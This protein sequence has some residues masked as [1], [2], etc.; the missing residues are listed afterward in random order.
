MASPP[1][2]IDCSGKLDARGMEGCLHAATSYNGDQRR[3]PVV[4]L[5]SLSFVDPAG[6]VG[7][8]LLVEHFC[9][10]GPKPVVH[11]PE[12]ASVGH[13]LLR[14]GLRRVLR[15]RARNRGAPR[16]RPRQR[17]TSALLELSIIEDTADVDELLGRLTD[18]VSRI[19]KAEL[20]YLPAD[21]HNFAAVIAELCRNIVDHSGSI[22]FVAAQRYTR[23]DHDR[24]AIIS[25]GD[26][27]V[28]LRATLGS[29]YPVN[30]W[31]DTEVLR[32][33]LLPEFSRHP[34]R[35]MGLTFVEKVASDYRGSL[36]LRSGSSRIYIR[37][38]RLFSIPG[39]PFPGTQATISLR[40]RAR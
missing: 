9:H 28:G 35:G 25:V 26:V 7:L 1:T 34:N 2:T 36:H 29:R 23:D 27:G 18:R 38:N 6:L 20:H 5:S 24:F 33:S 32:K 13:Y 3:S 17:V 16:G 39:A 10:R 31:S 12:D 21:V 8:A 19:L 4:D 22:G 15:G 37:G 11:Y 14:M 40:E 30:H